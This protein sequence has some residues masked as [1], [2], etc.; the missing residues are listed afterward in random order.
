[1]I[2]Y[3]LDTNICIYL[4]KRK[5]PAVFERFQTLEPGSIGISSITVAEL[6]YGVSKSSFPEKNNNALENFLIPL[7]ILD[8]SYEAA[9][10]YGKIRAR[11][12]ADGKT[13][14]PLDTLIGAHALSLNTILVTNNLKEF[15]RID[16]LKTENWII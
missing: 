9:V 7:E 1:M 10:T 6:H 3:L 11:L 12:E 8:F 15:S 5:P 13:I 4:I 14:G 2:S 16:G